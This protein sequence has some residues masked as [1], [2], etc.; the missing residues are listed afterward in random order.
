MSK[1]NNKKKSKQ[2]ITQ[3]QLH[4]MNEEW[5]ADNKDGR[6]VVF[7]SL[8]ENGIF[9]T[10]IL[11]MRCNLNKLLMENALPELLKLYGAS[12]M[13]TVEHPRPSLWQRIRDWFFP[14][15]IKK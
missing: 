5:C 4:A 6:A 7:F 12:P 1:R 9:S 13:P 11:G 3:E 10:N 14:F 15:N 2:E 8:S